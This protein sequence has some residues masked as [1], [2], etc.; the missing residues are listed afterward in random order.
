MRSL[1][2]PPARRA[3]MLVVVLLG[4]AAN[5]HAYL[6]P[7]TG[8]MMLQVGIAALLGACFSLKLFWR[9]IWDFAVGLFRRREPRED[10][11]DEN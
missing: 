3:A 2:L 5:A 6:D 4:T 10:E 11:V 9:Q 7:G 8:S 1:A